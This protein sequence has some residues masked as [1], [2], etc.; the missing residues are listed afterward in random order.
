MRYVI[1]GSNLLGAMELPRESDAAKRELVQ[2]LASFARVSRSRVDCVFDG[3]RPEGFVSHLGG[4]GV[5]FAHPRSADELIVQ[6]LEG[7]AAPATLVT[8]DRAL[9]ARVRGRRVTLERCVEFRARLDRI[10][11]GDDSRADGGVDWEGYFSDPKN[12]NV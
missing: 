2:R 4:L 7:A 1:D 6:M 12:R 9:G 10:P 11:T 3:A 5:R 8:N